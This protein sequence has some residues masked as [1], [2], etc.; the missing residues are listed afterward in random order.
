[1]IV[2][3]LAAH[4]AQNRARPWPTGTQTGCPPRGTRSPGKRSAPGECDPAGFPWSGVDLPPCQPRPFSM[5]PGHPTAVPTPGAGVALTRATS[6]QVA[7][8][9]AAHPGGC[10]AAGFPWSGLIYRRANPARFQWPSSFNRRA[11][12]G[13]GRCPYPGYQLNLMV[14]D[15]PGSNSFCTMPSSGGGVGA[16]ATGT[17]AFACAV[18]RARDQSASKVMFCT[19]YNWP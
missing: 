5:A 12:P 17:W 10:D 11:N 16:G 6:G 3:G 13:C 2:K 8:V 19:A 9:S 14:S 1:M 4:L 18:A 15:S 7:R